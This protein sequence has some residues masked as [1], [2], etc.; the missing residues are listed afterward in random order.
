MLRTVRVGMPGTVARQSGAGM[1]SIR[2]SVTRLVVLHAASRVS[3]VSGD[4]SMRLP[5]ADALMSNA[6]RL[7]GRRPPARRTTL[8]QLSPPP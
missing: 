2:Y 7:S 3:C 8:A 5:P 1:R 4:R 6:S